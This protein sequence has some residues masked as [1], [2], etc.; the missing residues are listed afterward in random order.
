MSYIGGIDIETT[1][2]VQP[3]GHRIIEMALCLYKESTG[4]LV[5]EYSKRY[6]PQRSIDPAAQAVHGIS[7]DDLI[8]APLFE[9]TAQNLADMLGRCSSVVA[10]NGEGFDMPFLVGEF[11]RIG[12]KPPEIH[13]IDTMLQGRWATPEGE[14]PSLRALCFACGVEYDPEKAHA[15]LYDVRVMMDCYFKGAGRGLF[16]RPDAAYKFVPMSKEK[17][18]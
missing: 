4:Q 11:V 1:G 13:L 6:N 18:R 2:L 16:K 15:A 8:G 14:L 7:V 12:V 9:D 5:A 3:D 17:K 10:H